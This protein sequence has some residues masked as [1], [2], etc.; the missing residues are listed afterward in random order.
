MMETKS[1]DSFT[2]DAHN[3]NKGNAAGAKYIDKSFAELGA[4]RSILVDKND[5]IIAGNKSH[6]A[7]IKNGIKNVIVVET[8]GTQLV[9]VKRTDVSIDSAKGRALAYADNRA[10]QINLTWDE[11]EI[12]EV[13]A[14][15]ADFH[16]EDWGYMPIESV[17]DNT[18]E[19]DRKREEFRA[20][21][22]AG[23]ITEDEEEYKEFVAKFEVKHTTDDCYTPEVVYD[24]VADWVAQTYGVSRSRF[25][26]P[27][28][29]GGNYQQEHYAPD[30]I[31]VDNPPFSIMAEILRWYNEHHVRFFL[32]APHLTAMSSSAGLATVIGTGVTIIYANGAEVNT[33]FLTNIAPANVRLCSAPSLYKAVYEANKQVANKKQLPCYEYPD[34]I[35]TMNLLEKLSRGGVDFVVYDDESI[36]VAQLD[37]QKE[38]GKALFGKAYMCTDEVA[39]R[40]RAAESEA[41]KTRDDVVRWELSPREK[42][43]IAG[44]VHRQG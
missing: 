5:N 41:A 35:V 16:L 20:R 39:A 32:F 4:G 27:F 7:A 17:V 14:D 10:A 1:I 30:D 3:F 38:S 29:P 42:E 40:R 24:A 12:Q 33:S 44:M 19:T 31:V 36:N 25:K 15:I 26:R 28:V 34:N 18:A 6:D 2:P 23:E 11:I 13:S 8:D 37:S 9:A 22:A 43:I 21:M